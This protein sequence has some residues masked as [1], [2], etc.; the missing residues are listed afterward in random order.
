MN[1]TFIG[2]LATVF[3]KYGYKLTNL[4]VTPDDIKTKIDMT[5]ERDKHNTTCQFLEN[6]VK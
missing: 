4:T 5:V 1:G 6:I 2:E 3:E